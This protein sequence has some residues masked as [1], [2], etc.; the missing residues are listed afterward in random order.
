MY[1]LNNSVSAGESIDEK[2]MRGNM[3]NHVPV[4]LHL[5]CEIDTSCAS[6]TVVRLNALVGS[7]YAGP[8]TLWFISEIIARNCVKWFEASHSLFCHQRERENL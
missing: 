1:D 2:F 7:R 8:Q 5:S 4:T 6:D 3:K